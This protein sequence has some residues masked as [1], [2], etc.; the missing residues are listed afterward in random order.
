[1]RGLSRSPRR[2]KCSLAGL[3]VTSALGPAV[4]PFPH[5]TR[6]L[7]P[8]PLRCLTGYTGHP[9]GESPCPPKRGPCPVA[10]SWPLPS[11]ASKVTSPP[12]AQLP[13]KGSG[14]SQLGP[15][16][17]AN[18]GPEGPWHR[19]RS[20]IQDSQGPLFLMGIQVS[21]PATPH[22]HLSRPLFSPS[23]GGV[24]LSPRFFLTSL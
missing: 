7:V 22:R 5:T 21:V 2:L 4:T 23:A 8:G 9:Q 20:P 11:L 18:R 3:A 10:S 19:P 17:A 13:E 1:M 14:L 15:G 6:Q 24:F 12:A 16:T